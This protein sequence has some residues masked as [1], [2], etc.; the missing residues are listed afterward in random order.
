MIG[1]KRLSTEP[2]R[3]EAIEI[4]VENV[5][6]HERK[7]PKEFIGEDGSGVTEE[8]LDWCRPLLGGPLLEFAKID[9][10]L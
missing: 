3:I 9:A 8:F 7:F 1:F 4:P 2:Y 10:V 6:L 5:M